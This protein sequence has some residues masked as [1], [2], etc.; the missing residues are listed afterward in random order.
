[1]KQNSVSSATFYENKICIFKKN[2]VHI[3]NLKYTWLRNLA[4]RLSKLF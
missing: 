1:M 3:I 2:R 4:K